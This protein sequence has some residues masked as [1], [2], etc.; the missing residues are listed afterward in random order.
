MTVAN[1][2]TGTRLRINGSLFTVCYP[3]TGVVSLAGSRGALSMLVAN[4]TSG[5]WSLVRNGRESAV[6]S[7]E[8]LA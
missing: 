3:G 7:F 6:E 4:K 5:A 8:V 2:T 1:L